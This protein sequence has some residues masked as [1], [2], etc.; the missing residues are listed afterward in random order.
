MCSAARSPLRGITAPIFRIP[1][2]VATGITLRRKSAPHQPP[3]GTVQTLLVQGSW[4]DLL[5]LHRYVQ[6]VDMTGVHLVLPPPGSRAA[7]EDFPSKA[8]RRILPALTRQWACSKCTTPLWICFEKA[9]AN[10]SWRI[11]ELRLDDFKRGIPCPGLSRW[12]MPFRRDTFMRAV[13]LA[14]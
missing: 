5:R 12:R 7:K 9:A 6:L 14:R 1:G 11:E 10:Y 2:F 4:M 13:T 8:V 3:I